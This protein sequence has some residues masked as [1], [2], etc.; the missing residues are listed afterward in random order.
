M[1][2]GTSFLA[3]AIMAEKYQLTHPHFPHKSLYYLGGLAEGTETILIFILFCLMPE[4]FPI[5]ASGFALI[6]IITAVIRVW[7]GYHTIRYAEQRA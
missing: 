7:T 2:T 4:H 1:G 3:Y 5:L 6:C